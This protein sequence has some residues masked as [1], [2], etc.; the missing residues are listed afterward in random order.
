MADKAEDRQRRL[1]ERAIQRHSFC[2]LATASADHPPHVTGVLYAAVD[3]TIYVSTLQSSIKA[4]NIGASGR[5]AVCI[6]V[7]RIPFAPPFCVQFQGRAEILAVDDATVVG[8]IQTGRLKKITS[9][10]ELQHPEACLAR[11]TPGRRV[12]TYGL[13]VPLRELLRDPLSASRSIEL[14]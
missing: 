14:A 13:G 5:A 11:I 10:G 1:V 7:R 9:H 12:A 6:P 4:R 3:R 8:V 2:A